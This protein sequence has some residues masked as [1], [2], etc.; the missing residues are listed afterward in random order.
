ML[1]YSLQGR[2]LGDRAVEELLQ[3]HPL[4]LVHHILSGGTT[5]PTLLV[6]RRFSSEAVNNVASYVDA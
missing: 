5:C 6:Q 1:Y 2:D 3:R 4:E